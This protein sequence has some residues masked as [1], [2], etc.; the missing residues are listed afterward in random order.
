MQTPLTTEAP[1]VQRL[2]NRIADEVHPLQI[3]MFGSTAR[4]TSGPDSDVDLLVVVPEGTHRR[5]TAQHLYRT[6]RSDSVPFD[7]VVATPS[8]LARHR[9]NPGLIYHSILRE[10]R[11]VYAA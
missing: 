11:T 9:N 10:G 5:R 8:D 7:L 6:I 2:V 1:A 3:I 4:G